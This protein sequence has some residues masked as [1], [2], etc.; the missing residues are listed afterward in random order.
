MYGKTCNSQVLAPTEV[1]LFSLS[2]TFDRLHNDKNLILLDFYQAFTK[3]GLWT[4]L[5]CGLDRTELTAFIS[6][7]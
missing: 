1:L 2:L 3:P 4:G 7:N 5:D 6:A